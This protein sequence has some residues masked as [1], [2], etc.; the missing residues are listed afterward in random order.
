MTVPNSYL[1]VEGF[2]DDDESDDCEVPWFLKEPQSAE[3][4]R[5]IMTALYGAVA[6]LLIP[7]G[8]RIG[9]VLRAALIPM[10]RHDDYQDIEA[11]CLA[12]ATMLA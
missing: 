2:G 8:V 1:E 7:S 12:V 6:G 10:H 5:V 3:Q 11:V 4:S 9:R